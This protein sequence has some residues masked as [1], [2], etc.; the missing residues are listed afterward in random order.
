[1]YLCQNNITPPCYSLIHAFLE[2]LNSDSTIGCSS[3]NSSESHSSSQNHNRVVQPIQAVLPDT[4]WGTQLWGSDLY[5][6]APASP[7]DCMV[8]ANWPSSFSNGLT[9][10]RPPP[11]FRCSHN[12]WKSPRPRS[13]SLFFFLL[14]FSLSL[15][16]PHTKDTIDP[17][18]IKTNMSTR[19]HTRT[20]HPHSKDT[21]D[22]H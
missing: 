19:T 4:S 13:P 14:L 1:M 16:S 10:P 9:F 7:T 15:F 22:S 2:R 21:S 11:L 18:N 3:I 6:A 5:N 8:S 20:Q 17:V 12:A